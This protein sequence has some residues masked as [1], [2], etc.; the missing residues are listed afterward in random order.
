MSG[1]FISYRR[2]RTSAY[3]G[4]LSDRLAGEHGR[5]RVFM[6]VDAID[7]G[8]DFAEKITL[9]I[10]RAD[11]TL[12]VIGEDWAGGE[13]LENPGDFVRIEVEEALRHGGLV[14]AVLVGGTPLPRAAALPA[15]MR[16]LL[17]RN[18]VELRDAS[19]SRDVD[20]LA[21]SL[22]RTVPGGGRR[23]WPGGA[24]ARAAPRLP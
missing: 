19:W 21:D 9:A 10:A 4:R 2:G 20:T 18:A 13:R 6:D 11:A 17:D 15:S 8:V 7:P 12:V 3:A 1:V 22:R 23:P 24:G 14:I 16:V 5:A